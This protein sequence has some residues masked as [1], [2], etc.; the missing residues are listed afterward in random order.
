MSLAWL[1]SDGNNFM[2]LVKILNDSDNH[3][4]FA[5]KFVENLLK[6]FWTKYQKKLIYRMFLPFVGYFVCSISTM[7]IA[8]ERKTNPTTDL[9]YWKVVTA[10]SV[11]MVLWL[12]QIY[13]E[14]VQ[15]FNGR[16]VCSNMTEQAKGYFTQFWNFNDLFHL[17]LTAIFVTVAIKDDNTITVYY[18][19]IIAAVNSLSM[20]LK[21]F[22]WL[23][24][25]E[26]TA[27]YIN[28]IGQTMTDIRSFII[29]LFASFLL[30]G[31]PM[32]MINFWTLPGERLFFD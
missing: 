13:L 28:L 23:R 2:G 30:F 14:F 15:L 18:M 29:L 9:E 26:T 17:T 10:G 6:Q 31:L 32:M 27:F 25:V 19:V 16:P 4:I 3:T 21:T 7:A 24:L 20:S 5:T 8:L 11:T 22:D 12:Y 1:F